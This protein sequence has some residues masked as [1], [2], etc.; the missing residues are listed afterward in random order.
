M[1]STNESAQVNESDYFFCFPF[2]ARMPIFG[3]K[4]RLHSQLEPTKS[5][6]VSTPNVE[7]SVKTNKDYA[8]IYFE[9]IDSI[10]ERREI[11]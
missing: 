1:E 5:F 6:S 7:V 2:F 9:G 8:N 10:Y 3:H 4:N 11:D